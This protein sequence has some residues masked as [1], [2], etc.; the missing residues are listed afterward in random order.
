MASWAD[1]FDIDDSDILGALHNKRKDISQL[2]SPPWPPAA[3]PPSSAPRPLPPQD[4]PTSIAAS[5]NFLKRFQKPRPSENGPSLSQNPG[6]ST[7]DPFR[8]RKQGFDPTPPLPLKA[9]YRQ[10]PSLDDA[11]GR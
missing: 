6:T 7:L 1:E 9:V 8:K 11:I 10:N 3:A 5:A 4:P 2:A